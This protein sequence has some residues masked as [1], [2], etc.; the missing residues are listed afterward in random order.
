MGPGIPVPASCTGGASPQQGGFNNTPQPKDVWF[1]ITVPANGIIAI[2]PQPGI[3]INDAAMALYSGT[4]TSLTQIACSDDNNYPGSA[5]DLKPFIK[6]TGL[7]PGSTVYLR[8]WAFN[9]TITGQFGICVQS[10]S[11][12]NCANALY[13]CDLDGYS[14]STSAA[15]TTDRPCNMRGN[16]EGPAPTY[17]YSP[18]ATPPPC[19]SSGIF[20]AIPSSP[21]SGS[22]APFC[23]VRLDNNSWIRFTAANT[24]ITL[25]VNITDC[26]GR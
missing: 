18:S 23:D 16:A 6:A 19:A 9:G 22:G 14:G 21:F 17:T 11:N 3:G 12:D 1:A 10:P 4:C 7:T 13:I 24:T 26:L 15:Y 25:T 8:Y 20:G 5:N 2:V